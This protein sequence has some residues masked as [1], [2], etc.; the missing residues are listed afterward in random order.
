MDKTDR[1]LL[2][3]EELFA[4]AVR[5]LI[6][7]K[8]REIDADRLRPIPRR[9]FR[10]PA[11][12]LVLAIVGVERFFLGQTGLAILKL[13][14]TLLLIGI[15]WWIADVFTAQNRARNYNFKLFMQQYY[16][17]KYCT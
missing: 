12:V 4:P 2:E 11:A 3:H 1:Y 5:P 8:L 9:P 16:R 17:A 15:V 10:R 6:R 7:S 14:S 13:V